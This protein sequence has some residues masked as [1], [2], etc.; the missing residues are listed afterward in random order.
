MQKIIWICQGENQEAAWGLFCVRIWQGKVNSGADDRN[1]AVIY[2]TL[3]QPATTG[4]LTL[5]PN[6]FYILYVF[7]RI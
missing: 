7:T 3:L 1:A 4:T 5:E 6:Y 2:H